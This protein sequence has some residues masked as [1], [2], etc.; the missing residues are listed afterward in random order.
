M[1][2]LTPHQICACFFSATWI[3]AFHTWEI[4][5]PRYLTQKGTVTQ[6][7]SKIGIIL[8]NTTLIIKEATLFDRCCRLVILLKVKLF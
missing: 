7:L 3:V 1:D 4:F 5:A 6:N 2:P 8:D